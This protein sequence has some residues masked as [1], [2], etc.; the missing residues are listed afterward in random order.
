MQIG[1]VL[2]CK[3]DSKVVIKDFNDNDIYIEYNGCVYKRPK[4]I[5]G[6]DLFFYDK[7]G[8]DADGYNEYGINRKLDIKDGS[9]ADV[10]FIPLET[11]LYH[12]TYGEGKFIK[13]KKSGKSLFI[14]VLFEIGEK[15]FVFPECMIKNFLS[16]KIS[17]KLTKQQ[18]VI[19]TEYGKIEFNKEKDFF[20]LITTEIDNVLY[21]VS[22]N[23]E[24]ERFS[25][26]EIADGVYARNYSGYDSR[27][28]KLRVLRNKPYFAAIETK[29]HGKL[30]IGKNSY[31]QIVDWADPVCSIYY[32]Y[33]VYIGQK[34]PGLSLVRDFDIG[35]GSFINFFDKYNKKTD[36]ISDD[37][38]LQKIKEQREDKTTHDIINSIRTNQYNILTAPITNNIVVEGCAGSGKT[39]IL[40]HRL[41]YI[42]RNN[43]SITD[44]MIYVLSP[45][46]LLI[47]EC[48]E[49]SNVLGV[50]KVAKYSNT[51]FYNEV[52]EKSA[53]KLTVDL[54]DNR[55][56]IMNNE[57]ICH[58]KLKEIYS[59]ESI[60][61]IYNSVYSIL[62]SIDKKQDFASMEKKKI[63]K[64]KRDFATK[65]NL[66]Y[67]KIWSEEFYDVYKKSREE[68]R[69]TSIENVSAILNNIRTERLSK[70]N[71]EYRISILNLFKNNEVLLSPLTRLYKSDNNS[72]KIYNQSDAYSNTFKF[73]NL[74]NFQVENTSFKNPFTEFDN[75]YIR[76]YKRDKCFEKFTSGECL[77]YLY[78]IILS[79][80]EEKKVI[81]NFQSD[82]FFE[83]EQFYLAYIMREFS[84][85]SL[86][87]AV[88][89]F[90]DEFQDYSKEEINLVKKVFPFA[91][92]NYW[93]DFNQR[94]N[95]KGISIDNFKN[96]IINDKVLSYKIN[97]NYRN[98]SEI[99][100]YIN[101]CFN[102]NMISI[103][104]SG[105][106]T[107]MSLNDIKKV[108]IESND[109]AAIIYGSLDEL[110]E[111]LPILSE[112][113]YDY[114]ILNPENE[115]IERGIFNILSVYR[116]KGLEFEKV[117]VLESKMTQKEKYVSMTRALDELYVIK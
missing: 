108:D 19:K 34:M 109:R 35:N 16:L 32:N 30:Y 61:S 14:I 4:S 74:I 12:N 28:N 89:C 99:T 33:P 77:L 86:E 115:K 13:F 44:N 41:H 79:L 60:N 62:Y 10:D 104:L 37:N 5:I 80:I 65:N 85:F 7:D 93:G 73:L 27:E 107:E 117:I 55:V 100:E 36:T 47:A 96:L 81:E 97:E 98:A 102:I 92:I 52:I 64:L 9:K 116:A 50:N 31:G 67:N 82:V 101:N 26:T 68:L 39:M 106:V 78:Y 57:T 2:F 59:F 105:T 95:G 1:E 6:V 114:N 29:E 63:L 110:Y 90:I 75:D 56:S 88:L 18:E 43:K 58:E 69:T 20:D 53:K 87:E 21:E 45:T 111:L 48:D 91:K 76:I 94:I 42:L 46:S 54:P 72:N 3:D 70:E 8:Y 83:W 25:Y 15:E 112:G 23:N 84:N 38:L 11:H 17:E 49:L 113:K 22:S 24:I 103:G 51:T 71:L 66:D 40:L